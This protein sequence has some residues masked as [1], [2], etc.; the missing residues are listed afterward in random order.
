MSDTGSDGLRVPQTMDA[1]AWVRAWMDTL[2]NH[3]G[4]PSDEGTMLAW[5]A[6]AIM[7]GYDGALR[8]AKARSKAQEG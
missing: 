1:Q 7:A 5:F 8:A 4:I 2:Q 6:N 3:P